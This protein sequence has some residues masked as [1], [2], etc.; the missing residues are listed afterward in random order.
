M[1]TQPRDR[2]LL[3]GSHRSPRLTRVRLRL[4]LR[5]RA[6]ARAKFKG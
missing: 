4:K 1:M 3:I 6:R 5:G 2:S